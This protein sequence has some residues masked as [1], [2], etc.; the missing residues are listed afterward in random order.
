M[1]YL[2]GLKPKIKNKSNDADTTHYNKRTFIRPPSSPL[3][4]NAGSKQYIMEPAASKWRLA[5]QQRHQVAA[6]MLRE[7]NQQRASGSAQTEFI[8]TTT[9]FT[10]GNRG[11]SPLRGCLTS[12]VPRINTDGASTVFLLYVQKCFLFRGLTQVTEVT[13]EGE[14]PGFGMDCGQFV[15]LQDVHVLTVTKVLSLAPTFHS[16]CL[17]F[18]AGCV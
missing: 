15:V 5:L 14:R 18:W 12:T 9:G 11:A 17:R 2:V 1:F 7:Q 6:L 13:W 4:L 3:Q 8:M 10:E 16:G